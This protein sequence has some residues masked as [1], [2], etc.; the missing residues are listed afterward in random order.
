MTATRHSDRSDIELLRWVRRTV[1]RQPELGH[2]EHRTSAFL[3]GLL[4]GL[5]LTIHRPA[6]CSLA[7]VVGPPGRPV[8]AMRADLDAIART[9]QTELPFA[10]ERSGV[11]HACGHDGHLAALVVLARRLLRRPPAAPTLLIFQQAEEVHPSG[12][13]QVIDGLRPALWPVEEVYGL[14]L[15]PELP[16]GTVGVKSGPLMGGISGV[17]VS[18][19]AAQGR[20][21]GTQVDVGAG[22]ALRAL[23]QFHSAVDRSLPQGRRPTDENPVVIHFGMAQAG[24]APNQPA[25]NGTIKATMRWLDRTAR[26]SCIKDLERIAA[27]VSAQTAVE[28]DVSVEHDIRPLVSNSAIAAERIMRA[29]EIAGIRVAADYPPS[30]LGV[31]DDF[32]C[33]LDDTSGALF[34]VGCGGDGDQDDLHGTRFNFREEALLPAIDLLELLVRGVKSHAQAATEGL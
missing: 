9:E 28:I 12:A 31:S 1:H 34:L 33:Y 5:G 14:H 20:A 27:D 30:P 3:E 26:D 19:R 23:S 2:E 25:L 21:H 4:G 22:D 10:S 17:T 32:G 18:I 24:E 11:M 13:R 29:C 6:P 7:V 16:E 8:V 15:W